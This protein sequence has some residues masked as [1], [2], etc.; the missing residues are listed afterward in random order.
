MTWMTDQGAGARGWAGQLML[1]ALGWLALLG[2][3]GAWAADEA[4]WPSKMIRLIVPAP[5]GGISDLMARLLADQLSANLKQPFVVENLPGGS[6]AIGV[7]AML[8]APPDGQAMMV[9]TSAILTEVPHVVKLPYDPPKDML[10]VADL[11]RTQLV[12]VG[13]PAV[14]ARTLE[15]VIAYVKANPGKLSVASYSAGTAAHYAAVIFNHQAGL[16]LQHVPYKGSP[17]AV[18]DLLAGHIPFAFEALPN[19]IKHVQAGKLRVYAVLSPKRTELLPGV[20]TMAEKGF[21][22]LNFVGWQGVWVSS[23]T[24]DKLAQR[25]HD[26]VDKAFNT[27]HVRQQLDGQG[28]E[29]SPPASLVQQ[30]QDFQSAYDRR[31]AIVK[32]FQIKAE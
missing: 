7:R 17:P 28:Y 26:E 15:E 12:L 10:Q 4:S 2:G 19:V 23:R 30:K 6:G 16:D 13:H 9:I 32:T 1:A 3:T 27:P 11:V 20:P 18:A 14:P 29:F 25:I 22:D 24:P 8:S 21:P 31:G 5:A